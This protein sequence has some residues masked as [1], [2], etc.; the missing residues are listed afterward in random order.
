[1]SQLEERPKKMEKLRS[2][3]RYN[4]RTRKRVEKGDE[5]SGIR[6]E[7]REKRNREIRREKY[8]KRAQNRER[9]NER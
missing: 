3:K 4:E 2:T 7:K 9:E 6:R 5:D 8:R 1:M